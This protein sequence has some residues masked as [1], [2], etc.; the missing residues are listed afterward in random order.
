M[1]K[2]S[3]KSDCT[4][5]H[6][7]YNICPQHCITMTADTEG[8]Q[9]PVIDTKRCISCGQCEEICPIKH[10]PAL[11]Q[12]PKLY[13]G[14][15]QQEEVRYKSSSGG[16]F[17]ALAEWIL[18]HE[19]VVYGAGMDEQMTVKQMRI[20][21]RDELHI[22]CGSKYVQSCVGDTFAQVKEDLGAK[23]W[24][25]YSGTSC[26]IAGLRNY[27]KR[28]YEKLICQDII[29][30]G[31]PSPKVWRLYLEAQ[32]SPARSQVEKA[33]FRNKSKGWSNYRIQLTF[34]NKK[35]YQKHHSKDLFMKLFLKNVILRPSCYECH[36]KKKCQVSDLT[37]GDFW[38][39]HKVFPKLYDDKGIS[40]I[41]VNSQKGQALIDKISQN[42]IRLGYIERDLLEEGYNTSARHSAIPHIQRSRFFSELENEGIV[43]TGKS[44]LKEPVSITKFKES[45][46]KKLVQVKRRLIKLR[47]TI[48][49]RNIREE[50]K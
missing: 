15:N 4:G 1:I 19:G 16:I 37:L 36:L 49:Y 45:V 33:E 32:K 25:Y 44:V 40:M 3:K 7:C 6:A 39:V 48:F 29:C 26:Q 2:I 9:Y 18:S 43:K 17:T 5:C 14:W 13:Y 47:N 50:L 41:L 23:R 35:T 38:G 8:F 30:H 10:E 27:L 34:K 11:M 28:E 24:V 21:A 46:I 42:D 12:E 22:L 31:V 20:S